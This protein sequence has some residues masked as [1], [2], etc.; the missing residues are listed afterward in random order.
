[1][2]VRDNFQV[3]LIIIVSSSSLRLLTCAANYVQLNR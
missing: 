1:M 3:R 2:V